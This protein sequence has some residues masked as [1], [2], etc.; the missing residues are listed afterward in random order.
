MKRARFTE[1]QII[2]ALRQRA[3]RDR[4]GIARLNDAGDEILRRRRI[5]IVRILAARQ[6]DI[7]DPR[8][9]PVAGIRQIAPARR[10]RRTGQLPRRDLARLAEIGERESTEIVR[11]GDQ[12]ADGI[13]LIRLSPRPRHRLRSQPAQFVIGVGDRA[14]GKRAHVLLQLQRSERA[15]RHIAI[16]GH[17]IAVRHR[18][19]AWEIGIIGGGNIGS[20]STR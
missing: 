19:E 18:D 10:Q 7:V 8:E 5:L 11:V 15:D 17:P 9:P 16:L 14:G 6:P 20:F 2:S 4:G 12:S 3:G 1:E 13:I